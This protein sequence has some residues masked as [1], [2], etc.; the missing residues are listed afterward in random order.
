MGRVDAPLARIAAGHRT[1]PAS[2]LLKACVDKRLGRS[3]AEVRR[4]HEKG[5]YSEFAELDKIGFH[6][7]H[8]VPGV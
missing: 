8:E 5:V 1:F 7:L 2:S 6:R 4:E 3:R